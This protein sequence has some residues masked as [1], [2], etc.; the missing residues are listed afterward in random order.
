M[1]CGSVLESSKRLLKER[2]IRLLMFHGNVG[3][4][5]EGRESGIQIPALPLSGTVI[6]VPVRTCISTAAKWHKYSPVS[7]RCDNRI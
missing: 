6:G 4:T 7:G 1:A 2:D 5:V 3:S